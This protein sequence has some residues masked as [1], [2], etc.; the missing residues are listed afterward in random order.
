MQHSILDR[1]YIAFLA[2]LIVSFGVLIVF[3][4]FMT[5]RSLVSEKTETLKNE[6][7]LIASQTVVGYINDKYNKS[8]L[9]PLFQYYATALDADIWYVDEY[10]YVVAVSSM[11][12]SGFSSFHVSTMF[13]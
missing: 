7:A 2:I 1:I 5:R 8:R 6:G 12:L 11:V 9:E 3:T 4:S 10:G 13:P